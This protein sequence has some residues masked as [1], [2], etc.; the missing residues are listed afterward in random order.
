MDWRSKRDVSRDFERI[1]ANGDGT[2]TADELA[3]SPPM[4]GQPTPRQA[5]L[6]RGMVDIVPNPLLNLRRSTE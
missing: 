2:I 5:R 4:N 1:D 6:T 3:A